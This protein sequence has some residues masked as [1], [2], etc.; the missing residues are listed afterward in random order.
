MSE[1]AGHPAHDIIIVRA[2][3][4]QCCDPIIDGVLGSLIKEYEDH[5]SRIEA[6]T[7]ER[8]SLAQACAELERRIQSDYA[9]SIISD[10]EARATRAEAELAALRSAPPQAAEAS[11]GK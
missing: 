4:T 10:L 3:Q 9:A 11:G 7:A 5:R 2:R 1:R 6:L 8:D